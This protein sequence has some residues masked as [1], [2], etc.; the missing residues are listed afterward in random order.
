MLGMIIGAAFAAGLVEEITDGIKKASIRNTQDMV[1]VNHKAEY[2]YQKQYTDVIHDLLGMGFTNVNAV[3]LRK[4][5][6]SIFT[7]KLYGQV[8][9]VSINGDDSFSKGE[10]FAKGAHV[11]VSFHVYKDSPHVTIPELEYRN[12]PRFAYDQNRQYANPQFQQPIN[13]NLNIDNRAEGYKYQDD[14]R[15]GYNNQRQAQLGYDYDESAK[16]RCSYCGILVP[17]YM[18]ICPHCGGHF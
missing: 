13:I 15:L 5:K 6:K 9:S 14:P 8:E 16:K 1:F 10:R 11:V 2:F 17:K 12:N 18:S 3:E 7:K 4:H